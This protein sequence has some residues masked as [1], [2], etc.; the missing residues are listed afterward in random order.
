MSP[1]ALPSPEALEAAVLGLR[2]GKLVVFPT[3]T[4]YGLG[5]DA[6]NPEAMKR[7]YDVKGRPADHPVIVHIAD[8]QQLDDWAIDIPPAAYRLADAFWPGPLTLILKKQPQVL[9]QVTGG[10]PTIGLRVPNHPVALALL[11]QFGD[12]IAAPSANR[13][14]QIS[15]TLLHR[16]LP[17]PIS[18]AEAKANIAARLEGGPCQIGIESTIVD[19]TQATA[20]I[21]R[22]G[23]IT[24]EALESVLGSPVEI[25]SNNPEE[26]EVVK[27]PGSHSRHYAPQTQTIL[28][29]VHHL[30]TVLKTM[31]PESGPVGVIGYHDRPLDCPEGCQWIALPGNPQGYAQGFYEALH[32]LDQGPC[33]IIVIESVPKQPK[34]AA[35]RNRISRVVGTDYE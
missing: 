15:P 20:R 35:V 32:Q 6:R 27:V 16:A 21:L 23:A 11:N 3:E 18:N 19:L 2:A 24:P 33:A 25:I 30:L 4:V 17:E 8:A 28:I 29:A 26:P 22:P 13:F 5:A 12:G 34:W 7:L 31:L 10:Q 14:Q 1:V 9:D